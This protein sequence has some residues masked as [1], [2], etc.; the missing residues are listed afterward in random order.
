MVEITLAEV[1]SKETEDAKKE[2]EETK[3]IHDN[4]AAHHTLG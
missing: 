3:E 1:A 4:E 2:T